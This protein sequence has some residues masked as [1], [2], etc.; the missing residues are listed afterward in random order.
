MFQ[1]EKSLMDWKKKL[2]ASNSLTNSDIEEL[3]SHLL[4]EIDALKKK[5]LTEEEAFYVACSRI[6]SV[7][8]LTSEYSIV[9]SNFLWIK[10]FL[11]LLSGYLIISFSEKLITTLSIFITTTFFK[12]IELHAHELTY[13]SFAVNILLSIVILCILFLPRIRGI[14]YFQAKFN[15][16]LVYKKW[17]LVVVFIIFIFMNT[18]GFSFINLPIM[19]NVGMSQYGYISVGHEYSG[20]IWT[21]TL[22]LLFILLS[23]SNSKKQVN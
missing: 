9:N 16:L 23:F 3:E 10:K 22:C 6:G 13:I 17:L 5:T 2:S 11:W 12:R 14:A 21:I 18:I 15:Y 7:D 1:L 4:D 19:R 20:L 8:L